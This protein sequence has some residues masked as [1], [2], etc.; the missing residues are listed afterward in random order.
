MGDDGYLCLHGGHNGQ[1]QEQVEEPLRKPALD[2]S[3]RAKV[4]KKVSFKADEEVLLP[5]PLAEDDEMEAFG[6]GFF[7]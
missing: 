1:H 2:T 7:H 5:E 4:L 3:K 6:L